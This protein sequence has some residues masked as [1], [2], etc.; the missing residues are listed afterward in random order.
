MA[1]RPRP[2]QLPR[3]DLA[4][5]GGPRFSRRRKRQSRWRQA[6]S[7]LLLL[8]GG[9]GILALETVL[10]Q[11][12]NALLLVSNAIAGLI[13]GLMLL[14]QGLLQLAIVLAVVSLALLALL[15]LVGGGVRL[16]RALAPGGRSGS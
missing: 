7:A 4:K 8:L 13:R 1:Q 14:G 6:G 10:I 9:C 15:L 12:L 3:P 11:R 5:A 16:F 2:L